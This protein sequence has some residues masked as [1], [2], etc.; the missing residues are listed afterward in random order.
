LENT[1]GSF[2]CAFGTSSLQSNISGSS[3]V[4]IGI[5]ALEGLMD[6]D[7]NVAIGQRAG[8]NLTSGSG[9]VF[10]GYEAGYNETASNRLYISN[11]NA[12]GSNALVYGEFDN[13]VFRINGNVGIGESPG[14][15]K[16]SVRHN[17]YGLKIQNTNYPANSWEFFQAPTGNLDLYIQSGSN[18]GS[19]DYVSGVYTALSDRRM[20]ENIQPMNPVLANVMKLQ[21][22][23]YTFIADPDH[24][25]YFGFIAQEVEQIFPHLV[26]P[27]SEEQ[28]RASNYTM[29]Y[30]GFGVL[31]IKA[32]QEQQTIIDAQ[33]ARIAKLEALVQELIA[34]EN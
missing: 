25:P 29:D 33:E 15:Y 1:T 9:N 21:A 11:S 28:G 24:K 22:D 17:S 13:Q 30:S 18:I 10:L 3:N 27:P 2:N 19:F 6:G 12:D 26:T 20:K 32:I 7:N 8:N 4:G 23:N 31:A 14:S 34:K 5:Y 16:L